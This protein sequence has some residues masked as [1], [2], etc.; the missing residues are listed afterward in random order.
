MNSTQG[1]TEMASFENRS[2]FFFFIFIWFKHI[3][4]RNVYIY[5]TYKSTTIGLEQKHKSLFSSFPNIS[6]FYLIHIIIINTFSR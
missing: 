2:F 6:H 1:Y 4:F 5:N 3:Y